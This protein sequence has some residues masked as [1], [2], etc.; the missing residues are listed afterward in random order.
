LFFLVFFVG[1]IGYIAVHTIANRHQPR[2]LEPTLQQRADFLYHQF[3]QFEDC[4]TRVREEE[5]SSYRNCRPQPIN[6][7]LANQLSPFLELA[8]EGLRAEL[9]SPTKSDGRIQHYQRVLAEYT[10]PAEV[11]RVSPRPH[12]IFSTM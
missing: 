8:R 5:F 2:N 3:V 1:F 10:Q 4:L 11:G 12:M 9:R 6:F 7:N